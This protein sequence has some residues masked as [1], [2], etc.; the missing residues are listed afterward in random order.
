MGLKLPVLLSFLLNPL[1][2]IKLSL[3][4]GLVHVNVTH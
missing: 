2:F 1:E 4:V 3:I